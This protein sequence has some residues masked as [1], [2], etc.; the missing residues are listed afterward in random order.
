MLASET[1]NDGA[2]RRLVLAHGFTQTGRCW[3]DFG[4]E[5]ASDR[6]VVRVDM[7][8]HGNSGRGTA[9]LLHA[10]GL[11]GHTG[12]RGVYVGYSMGGRVA[13]HLALGLTA[14]SLD[15]VDSV[16]GLVLI[17]ATAGIDDRDERRERRAQDEILARRIEEHGVE[18]FID[19]WLALDL[20][21]GLDADSNCRDER[22][23]N[24]AGELA[25]SLRNSGTG[26]QEP[27]WDRLGGLTMPVLVLAGENDAKFTELGR[28]LAGGI[29]VNATFET[30]PGAGHTTH[31][32][33]PAE[34]AMLVRSWLDAFSR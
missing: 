13:L 30:V 33:R 27:L 1:D 10:A 34:T 17:G 29:G 23:T 19:E 2:G 24:Q 5:L 14:H 26:T 7:P 11:L 28:R 20:F 32:E 18:P 3:S 9:D 21:A 12:G 25:N 16:E 4:T 15:S 31:L 6:E 8:G 22:L